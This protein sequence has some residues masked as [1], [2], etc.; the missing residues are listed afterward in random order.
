MFISISRRFSLIFM[1]NSYVKGLSSLT[2]AISNSPSF[3]QL[4]PMIDLHFDRADTSVYFFSPEKHFTDRTKRHKV[5][6]YFPS[7]DCLFFF[8]FLVALPSHPTVIRISV[9]LRAFPFERKGKELL[10]SLRR[11]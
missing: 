4:F 11:N 5:V 1:E 10:F 2:V 6:L 7:Y 9:Y 8:L 3:Y